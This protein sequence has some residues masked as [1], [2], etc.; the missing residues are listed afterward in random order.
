M[1]FWMDREF[2]PQVLDGPIQLVSQL[3]SHTGDPT[4]ESTRESNW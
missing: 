3:V 4:R 2:G 1:S